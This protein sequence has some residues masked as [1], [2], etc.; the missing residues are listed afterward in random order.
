[1]PDE[2]EDIATADHGRVADVPADRI[3]RRHGPRAARPHA[4][5]AARAARLRDPRLRRADARV[6]PH[7]NAA[8]GSVALA[9]P[10]CSA[11]TLVIAVP[12]SRVGR[13]RIAGRR[14]AAAR[15][16][17][18]DARR[19]TPQHD[20]CESETGPAADGRARPALPARA[21]ALPGLGRSV[22]APDG[23][24]PARLRVRAVRRPRSA[25]SPADVSSLFKYSIVQVRM[26]RDLDAGIMHAAIFWGFVI[27]TVGTADRVTFGLVHTVVAAD[28][29]WLAVAAAACSRP[30]PVRARR[31]GGG[32]LR[33]LPAARLALSAPD[34]AVARRRSSSCC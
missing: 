28:P 19:R 31:A 33:A 30:E 25:T 15:P 23:A 26:F 3:D 9:W 6:R 11:T 29:G 2:L 16:R 20:R 12:G 21:A 17:A 14:R 1:M 22:R 32:R 34:D 7:E 18:R 4:A 24:P 10:A 13:A 8:G 5:D 27:L